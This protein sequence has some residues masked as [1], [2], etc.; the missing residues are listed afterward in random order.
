MTA[1]TFFFYMFSAVLLTSAF[2]VIA[3]RNPVHSVLWLILG[4]VNAA[5]LFILMAPSSSR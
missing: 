3:S 5:G 1:V 2:L 4:F